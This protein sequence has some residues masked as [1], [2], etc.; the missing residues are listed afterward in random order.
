[1]K[2]RVIYEIQ[3]LYRDNFRVTGYEFG[4]GQQSVCI[5]GS[6]R[7]NEIQQLYSCSRLI[8]QLKELE[9]KGFIARGH[10]IL[11]IPC[12][13]SYSMNIGKRFWSTDNTD[14]NSETT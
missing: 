14:I 3:A 7:G 8:R 6:M 9:E 11:V 5:V 2:K 13:N 10:K 12:L 4:E 1:M